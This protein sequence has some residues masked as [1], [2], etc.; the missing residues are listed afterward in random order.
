LRS[1]AKLPSTPR[2][3][4]PGFFRNERLQVLMHLHVNAATKARGLGANAPPGFS[5][6]CPF[7]DL[8]A[9]ELPRI[10]HLVKRRKT[11]WSATYRA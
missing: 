8:F 10:D 2:G 1:A 9:I 3:I 6:A 11:G 4:R 5:G 7:R